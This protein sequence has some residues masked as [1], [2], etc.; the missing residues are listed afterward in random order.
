MKRTV[1]DGLIAIMLTFFHKSSTNL[2]LILGQ[3]RHSHRQYQFSFLEQKFVHTDH[4]VIHTSIFS[5]KIKFSEN[6]G[7]D[8]GENQILVK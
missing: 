5:Q 4:I 3:K 2:S 8:T 7:L 6:M 1:F